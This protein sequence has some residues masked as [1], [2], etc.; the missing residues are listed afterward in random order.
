MSRIQSLITKLNALATSSNPHEAKAA[1]TKAAELI[2]KYKIPTSRFQVTKGVLGYY[3]LYPWHTQLASIVC[4]YHG[5]GYYVDLLEGEII[6]AGPSEEIVTSAIALF[7]ALKKLVIRLSRTSQN[8]KAYKQGIVDGME[9]ALFANITNLP[10][11][12]D[13]SILGKFESMT[14]DRPTGSPYA[15][16]VGERIW[17]DKTSKINKVKEITCLTI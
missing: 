7:T 4:T 12:F 3:P 13:I 16:R 1:A 17:R 11:T 14:L 8:R 2:R 10:P 15:E 6:V 5:C 9:N